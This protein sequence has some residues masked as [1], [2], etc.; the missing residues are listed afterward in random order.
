MLSFVGVGQSTPKRTDSRGCHP[1]NPP[2][3]SRC[4]SPSLGVSA[5]GRRRGAAALGPNLLP[6]RAGLHA[7]CRAD[8]PHA[9]PHR[10][11]AVRVPPVS[12]ARLPELAPQEPLVPR[13]PGSP[14]Q[15]ARP[16][17]PAPAVAG[18]NGATEGGAP[19]NTYLIT[20]CG[21]CLPQSCYLYIVNK[22]LYTG[23]FVFLYPVALV[24]PA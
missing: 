16:A 5:A 19:P 13:P 21:C 20:S 14:A 7:S 9:L 18:R 3:Y 15:P 8:P 6:V 4:L 11:E 22:V 23:Y 10:R 1:H 2:H 12:M 17:C 24:P